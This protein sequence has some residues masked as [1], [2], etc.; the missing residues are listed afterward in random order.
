M[1]TMNLKYKFNY[2][3]WGLCWTC[4]I[5]VIIVSIFLRVANIY[6]VQ[7]NENVALIIFLYY[8]YVNLLYVQI[9]QKLLEDIGISVFHQENSLDFH[10]VTGQLW[11]SRLLRVCNWTFL[12]SPGGWVVFEPGYL[13]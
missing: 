13:T 7:A 12:R 10:P 1:E 4:E 6:M 11:F 5:V 9:L 2:I 3:K 8:I